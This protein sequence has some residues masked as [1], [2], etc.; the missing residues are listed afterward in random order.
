M[1]AC[2]AVEVR[3]LVKA[4]R[5]HRGFWQSVRWPRR[6]PDKL[7]LDGIDLSVE[8]GEVVG[9]IGENGAGK[10]TLLKIVATIITPTAGS[11]AVHGLDTVR[12][13]GKVRALCTYTF[14]DDRSFYWRLTGRQNLTFFAAINDLHGA[15]ARER[16]VEVAESLHITRNLDE[17][18]RFCSAGIRQRFALARA[19]IT[20]PRVLLLDEPTR[21]ID[22]TEAAEIWKHVR[23]MAEE[24]VTVLLATHSLA[25]AA[26]LC[27]RVLL[28]RNGRLTANVAAH[29][30]DLAEREL[31]SYSL[32][33]VGCPPEV[34]QRLCHLPG[35][36]DVAYEDT[37][38]EQYLEVHSSTGDLV[39][40]GL[41][42]ALAEANVEVHALERT[43][44]I[45]DLFG[46]MAREGV[47]LDR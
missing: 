17:P 32:R 8:P 16:I 3:G 29:E 20:R 2:A 19:L 25:E 24:G 26:A 9:I 45:D 35:I 22:R 44:S 27:D 23:A 21:S 13:G 7:V 42:G 6:E 43:Q 33:V 18:F 14:G 31:R 37:G 39:L 11:V 47:P 4:F 38:V 10:S 36:R 15:D 40:A 12:H 30:I 28:L 34:A 1:P 46:E 5:S 41:L